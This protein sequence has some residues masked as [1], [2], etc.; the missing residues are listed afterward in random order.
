MLLC[1]VGIASFGGNVFGPVLHAQ[2]AE[3]G[4]LSGAVVDPTG[5][6]IPKATVHI[7]GQTLKRDLHADGTGRFS[8]AL[9]AGKYAVT[10]QAAGF[11]TLANSVTVGS[12]GVDAHPTLS[13]RLAVAAKSEV[14]TVP[15]DANDSTS[16]SDNKSATVFKGS[17]LKALSDD[18][19]TF[20]QEIT[21]MAGGSGK[22]PEILVDGFVNGH[23]P[24]KNT[25]RE[26]RIN[27]NPYSAEYDSLGFGRVEIFTKPGTDSFHGTLQS[28]GNDDVFNARNPYDQ[29]VDP[30]Y[31]TL[32][33][34]GTLSGPI[35]RRTSFFL[36]GTYNDTQNNAIVDAP[37]LDANNNQTTLSEAV[38][39]PQKTQDYTA[40]LDRQMT[41]NNTLT[42]KYEYVNSQQNN[43]G[44]GL[45][46]LP[47]EGSNI[48]TTTQTLQVSDDQL[49]G[50]HMVSEVHFQYI[51]TRLDQTPVSNAPTITIEGAS[52]GGGSPAQLLH[53]NQDSYEFQE[54]FS[55][56]RGKHFLRLGGRY[57]LLR[58]A[59]LA[60]ASYNG[61][62]TFPSLDA[63][64][65]TVEGR[66]FG[67]T[68]FNL[69]NGDP[70][71][72]VL[73]GNLGAF[74]EDEWKISGN[75]TLNY[76]MRFETQSAIP[77]H[78]DPAP[79]FGFAW[80]VGQRPKKH[81][82]V[83][84]RGGGGLFYDRFASTNILTAIRQQSGTLQPSYYIQNPQFY[85]TNPSTFTS[86]AFLA[87]LSSTPPT[88]Y[89]IAPNLRSEY[90]IIGGLSAERSIGKI[91]SV[92]ATYF[93]IRGD[94]Q[95]L[96]RNINAP[97]P[98]T[99]L[100]NDPGSGVRPLGGT[101]NIYQFGSGGI[102]KSNII[103]ANVNLQPTRKISFFGFGFYS[104]S[105]KSDA[106]GATSFPT[107]QYDPSVD[108]G[109]QGQPNAQLFLGG[110]AQ[111]PF[112]FTLN[113]F[114]SLQ[115]GSPFNITTGTDL[116]GDTIYNDRPAFATATNANSIVYKTRFG[117]FDANPQP[118]ERTIPYNYGD[119]PGFV[120][121][122]ASLSRVFKIGPR[123]VAPPPA[124]GAPAAKA[125]PAKPDRP[126]S[127]E[128]SVEADNIFNHVNP[129]P[130]VGVLSSP[131][132]G[133]SISLNSPFSLGG[134]STAS[135]R[136]VTLRANFTF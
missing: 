35:N 47:T 73:T 93:Y 116:N 51:R 107:N 85:S 111:L 52:N 64:Q 128:F 61:Q 59:N 71:A 44:V 118:G 13:A 17:A 105:Q 114:V 122:E 54:Y 98:G 11:E 37:T 119:S 109:R 129:G 30:P 127:L 79:R 10:I 66:E 24:P 16:A 125:P 1:S 130:P 68:Q 76:G 135:N 45:L 46:L 12:S 34:N 53:D 104:P 113:P 69:T 7:E 120:F 92:S 97:L 83:V 81:A 55:M 3:Q 133:Q 96:S 90:G 33:L 70:S 88:L 23:F 43:S 91:G 32:I 106:P 36:G 49:I 87:S 8:V 134:T 14:V 42:A 102:V 65:A 86:P 99:Y 74:A 15:E 78:F 112:G 29:G 94:H 2:T 103:F 132:F 126:Y 131:F 100:P 67:A 60:T 20:Q 50:S 19:T 4:T 101:Q 108:Y 9:P 84:L 115:T 57:R 77:D 110:G 6:R 136:S 39:N 95:F 26:V 117:N 62:F 75:F 58:D 48:G 124:K 31:Y 28:S 41:M 27:R 18:D 89:N 63:Y 38:R 123:P 21:A 40:R 25:I 121:V 80:A 72:V 5:A 56:E 82:L 22:P